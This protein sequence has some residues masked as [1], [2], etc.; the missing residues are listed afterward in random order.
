MDQREDDPITVMHTGAN[1]V[2]RPLV[3]PCARPR[4][5]T[6]PPPTATAPAAPAPA[7]PLPTTNKE[8]IVDV[9]TMGVRSQQRKGQRQKKNRPEH[10]E[11]HHEA[12]KVQGQ[13]NG[14]RAFNWP[15]DC[16]R[17]KDKMLGKREGVDMTHKGHHKLCPQKPA[18]RDKEAKRLAKIGAPMDPKDKLRGVR[19]FS[20]AH[21]ATFFEPR[22]KVT[23]EVMGI[24]PE[25]HMGNLADFQ[26]PMDVDA[27]ANYDGSLKPAAKPSKTSEHWEEPDMD[28]HATVSKAMESNK[29]KSDNNKSNAPLAICAVVQVVAEKVFPKKI[30]GGTDELSELAQLKLG[31]LARYFD[32]SALGMKLPTAPRDGTPVN[33][34]YHMIEGQTV[35]LI[36]WEAFHPHIVIDCPDGGC[37]GKLKRVRTSCSNDKKLFPIFQLGGPPIWAMKMKYKCGVCS[38][39]HDGN[40]PQVLMSLPFWIRDACPVDP[41]Y[42]SSDKK[43]KWHLHRSIT[44][45]FGSLMPTCGSGDLMG[46][47][48]YEGINKACVR[49]T[50]EYFS[51]HKSCRDGGPP[52][53]PHPSN[54]EHFCPTRSPTGSEIRDLFTEAQHSECTITGFSDCERLTR[55]IQSVGTKLSAAQDHTSDTAKNYQ[56]SLGCNYIWDVAVETGEI[57]CAVLVKSTK[58]EDLAHAA[59]GLARRPHFNPKVLCCDTWPHNKSFWE[60]MYGPHLHGRLGLFHFQH[61]IVDTLR[62]GHLLY[63]E[64]LR[65]LCF[66]VHDWHEGDFADLVRN[67]KDGKMGN[68]NQVWTDEEIDRMN[69]TPQ[70]KGMFEGHLRKKVHPAELMRH[71]LKIWFETFAGQQDPLSKKNLFT[72]DTKSALEEQMKRAEDVADT[73]PVEKLYRTQNRGRRSKAKHDLLKKKSLRC[74]SHL[75]SFHNKEKHFANTNSRTDLADY[76]NLLGTCRHNVT[77]RHREWWNMLPLEERAEIIEYFAKEPM[78]YNHSKLSVINQWSVEAGCAEVPFLHVRPL[79]P[80]NGE[81]FFGAHAEAS[82]HR[83]RDHGVNPIT[84]RCLCP[85]CGGH[86]R[87]LVHV[88]YAYESDDKEEDVLNAMPAGTRFADEPSA[89][90]PF[91]TPRLVPSAGPKPPPMPIAPKTQVA[92]SQQLFFPNPMA[93]QQM[94]LM[95]QF[96]MQQMMCMA[97]HALPMAVHTPNQ[98]WHWHTPNQSWPG[99]HNAP[100]G[101][102]NDS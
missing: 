22:K 56:K 78:H 54:P 98:S 86:P 27:A 26:V 17:C 59:E 31:H 23:N 72:M 3:N 16:A 57:A 52:L 19:T 93:L 14:K 100:P 13:L 79:C 76:L 38:K 45:Q 62:Q 95:H 53:P 4:A 9:D 55:E 29:F 65:Q 47:I 58:A 41:Q 71:K 36:C 80:D 44:D 46:R 28:W 39:A 12:K 73:I 85:S 96:Q 70:F 75:E 64:A 68:K 97:Q 43:C 7:P 66:A 74:E 83:L 94:Q 37:N 67:L 61:R 63:H 77:M 24:T 42:I 10:Q 11:K 50:A 82:K 90:R 102:N 1:G 5:H 101:A 6:A 33:P 25:D 20:K 89:N 81:R 15:V 87:D 60:M 49:K 32:A 69:M 40:S 34:H 91:R 21:F 8:N 35:L 30:V 18:P 92:P 2:V 88:D 99:D 48:I 51:Y 84:R